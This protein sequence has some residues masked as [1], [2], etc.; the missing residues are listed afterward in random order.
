MQIGFALSWDFACGGLWEQVRGNTDD[1]PLYVSDMY[2]D[3]RALLEVI[4]ETLTRLLAVPD[5]RV[6]QAALNGFACLK[7]PAGVAVV[8]RFLKPTRR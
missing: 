5:A 7:H 6:R 8:Q 2:G 1:H 4:L 3:E